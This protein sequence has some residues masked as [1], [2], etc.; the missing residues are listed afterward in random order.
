MIEQVRTLVA[1]PDDLRALAFD[2]VQNRA[3]YAAFVD[4][5]NENRCLRREVALLDSPLG[6]LASRL[7]E[8]LDLTSDEPRPSLDIYGILDLEF[9]VG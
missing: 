4:T 1:N 2:N 8:G 7:F 9:P 5:T 6:R 3:T